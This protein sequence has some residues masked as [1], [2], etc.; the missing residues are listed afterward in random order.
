MDD[1]QS[2]LVF[3]AVTLAVAGFLLVMRS[4][5]ERQYPDDDSRQMRSMLAFMRGTA[6]IAALLA[7][8]VAADMVRR[9]L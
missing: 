3:I 7:L 1:V 8:L 4:R 2:H 9:L 6:S 5:L